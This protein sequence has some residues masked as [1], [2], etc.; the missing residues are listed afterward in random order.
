MAIVRVLIT[1]INSPAASDRGIK[2]V[3]RPEGWVFN[4]N[5]AKK[6][7]AQY[8]GKNFLQVRLKQQG[9]TG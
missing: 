2:I 6:I 9:W 3:L 1:K 8:Q 5:D 4:P 7:S